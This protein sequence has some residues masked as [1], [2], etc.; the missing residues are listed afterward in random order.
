MRTSL[1]F[2]LLLSSL[3]H[4]YNAAL[5]VFGLSAMFDKLYLPPLPPNLVME[6]NRESLIR[7]GRDLSLIKNQQV[8][9]FLFDFD[10]QL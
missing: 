6:A 7:L 4:N 8:S 2:P 10:P 5:Q 9:A 3:D 1:P